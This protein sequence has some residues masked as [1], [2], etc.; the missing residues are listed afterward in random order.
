MNDMTNKI[1]DFA[2]PIAGGAG[3]GLLSVITIE[4]LAQT[5][6]SALIFS[7]IGAVVGFGVKKALDAIFKK[8]K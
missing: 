1:L 8:K 3:G 4:S 6:V 2:F 7:F 5:A